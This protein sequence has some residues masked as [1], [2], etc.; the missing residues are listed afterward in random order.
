MATWKAWAVH[1]L[2]ASGGALALFAAIAAALH[3]W[4]TAFLLLG[5]AFVVDGIDGPLARRV[6]VLDRLPA[7]N[8]VIL[9]LVVDYT[10]YVFVPAVILVESPLLSPP[11]GA[12]AAVVVA[13]VG[14]LYFADTRMKTR[15]SAFRGFPAVWNAVVYVLMVL[16]PPRADHACDPRGVRGAQLRAGRVRPPGPRAPLAGADAAA[17]SRLGGAGDPRASRRFEPAAT[18]GAG[19]WPR[20]SLFRR[21]WRSAAAD[22]LRSTP[23]PEQP[24]PLLDWIANPSIWASLVTLTAMEIV[25]GIDNVIFISIIVGRLPPEEGARARR[26]GLALALIFRIALL[27]LLFVLIGLTKPL[28]TVLG[29]GYSVRDLILFAGGLFLLVKATREIHQDVEGDGPRG[30]AATRRAASRRSS[31]RSSSSTSSSRSTRS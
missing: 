21:G 18:G 6:H 14:A 1:L 29:H 5:I 4:Q 27:S 26:I 15:E 16:K 12:I 3:A 20:Q 24:M 10:T 19:V 8:G 13:V 23:Q 30:R 31:R 25:L 28:F 22:A 11:F 17:G 2:T 9:D 7:I